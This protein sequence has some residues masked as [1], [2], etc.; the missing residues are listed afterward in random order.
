MLEHYLLRF[1]LT[2]YAAITWCLMNLRC[3]MMSE[4]AGMFVWLANDCVTFCRCQSAMWGSSWREALFI[5]CCVRCSDCPRKWHNSTQRR[6]FWQSTFCT[7][8]PLCTRRQLLIFLCT[9]VIEMTVNTSAYFLYS[10]GK[11]ACEIYVHTLL[12]VSVGLKQEY[13]E[14]YLFDFMCNFLNTVYLALHP[15]FVLILIYN[16]YKPS[17]EKP[18]VS[19]GRALLI[20][21]IIILL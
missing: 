11:N 1:L 10:V 17:V 19:R 5:P 8:V 18:D 2:L 7:S 20:I 6:L 14:T 4:A 21:T 16:G 15:F 13:C 9:I 3:N 12:S